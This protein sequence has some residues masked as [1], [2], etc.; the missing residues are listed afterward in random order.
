M[1]KFR[2]KKLAEYHRTYELEELRDDLAN[3]RTSITY[4]RQKIKNIEVQIQELES[5]H[6]SDI[7]APVNE[8][9]SRRSFAA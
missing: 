8:Y 1:G 7:D 3:A 5:V 9:Q 2:S 4:F 6:W